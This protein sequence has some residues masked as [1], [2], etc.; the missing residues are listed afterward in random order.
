MS[1]ASSA[2]AR[3]LEEDASIRSPCPQAPQFMFVQLSWKSS[4]NGFFTWTCSM[5]SPHEGHGLS[6]CVVYVPIGAL[7]CGSGELLRPVC[8]LK[9][10]QGEEGR[11]PGALSFA[12][13]GYTLASALTSI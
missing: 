13:F 12:V 9:P 11:S 10:F 7:L 4:M 8:S 5:G 3:L 2:R 1:W 6:V